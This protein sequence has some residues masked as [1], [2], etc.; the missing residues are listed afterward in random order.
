MGCCGQG[1]NISA[2][3]EGCLVGSVLSYRRKRHSWNFL[4]ICFVMPFNTVGILYCCYALCYAIQ[5]GWYIVLLLCSM[6]CHLV[7]LVYCIVAVRYV[8]PFS[9]VGI[10]YC[11]YAVCL[12][13]LLTDMSQYSIG[14]QNTYCDV[15]SY[16]SMWPGKWVSLF[17]RKTLPP[18]S[19]Q[20]LTLVTPYQNSQCE[21]PLNNGLNNQL[22]CAVEIMTYLFMRRFKSH[23]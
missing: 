9:T 7:R 3:V 12:E 14:C 16:N 20:K 8:M 4:V 6:L 23:N 22:N 21:I 2:F 19:E 10:L 13:I 11:C 5:Y 18:S 1:K 15:L 17:R